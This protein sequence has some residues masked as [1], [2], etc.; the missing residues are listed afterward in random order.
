MTTPASSP[1]VPDWRHISHG[2]EIPTEFYSDQP[3]IV[4]TDDGAW[5][6][7]LTTGPRREGCQG[8][9]VVAMRSTDQ[10][11]TWT[12]VVDVEPST[13][14]EASYSVLLKV[15]SGRIYVFY[16]H[17]TNNVRRV[18]ADQPEYPDGWC[19]RV[20]SLGYHVFKYSDDHGRTWSRE[21]YPIPVREFEIDRRNA[22]GGRLRYFWNVGR[23][24]ILDGAA[25]TSLHK[26]G[27]FGAGFFT[28]S[29]GV[30]LR[31]PNLLTEPDP[32]R[33]TWETLPDGDRGIRTPAGGGPIAEEHSYSVLSDGSIYVVFRTTDGHPGCAVSR[34]GGHTWTPSRYQTYADGRPMKHPRAAN[35]AWRL[36]NGRF[37]YWFHHHGGRSY[38]DRNPV[39]LCGGTEVDGPEGRTIAW[40]QPEIF[41]Y[42]DDAYVRMSY[43]DLIED[44]GRVWLTETQKEIARTHEVPADFLATLTGEAPLSGPVREGLLLE[45]GTNGAVPAEAPAPKLADFIDRAVT[46]PNYPQVSFRVGFTLEVAFTLPDLTGGRML[47]DNRR[48]DGHGFALQTTDR[49]TVE[50]VL[51]D[52]RTENR[53][54]CDPGLLASGQRHHLVVV[55]DGGPCIISFIVDGRFCDGGTARE[56]GWGRFSPNLRDVNGRDTLRLDPDIVH[57][58]RIYGR[59][60]LTAEA[61]ANHQAQA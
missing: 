19:T 40:S 38:G 55:V 46:P 29:E 25:Y 28:S 47:L 54:E 18:K 50:I 44:G 42:D 36:S 32:A 31:S 53:W 5:L 8:Q 3:Y 13:G 12:E 52:G 21:R 10:G 26:V 33:I 41:L 20:D 30:L 58:A 48:P 59:R 6:C 51:H 11:Q 34:D 16:N 7:T 1:P 60:L 4:I 43:P 45:L 49:G 57:L 14:P 15:P 56:F 23:P 61:V 27:G 2:R 9:H 39:W 24:F 17:N 22:D 37:L 35:F